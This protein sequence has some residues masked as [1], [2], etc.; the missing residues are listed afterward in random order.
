[1]DIERWVRQ[2]VVEQ[3]AV[4]LAS[5]GGSTLQSIGM[6]SCV[7][8]EGRSTLATAAAV[9][10]QARFGRKTV[11]VEFDFEKPSLAEQLGLSQS[12]GVAEVLSGQA[13]LEQSVQWCGDDLGVLVAGNMSAGV[14]G[15]L[16]QLRTTDLMGQLSQR[17]EV[18]VVDLPPLLPAGL[19]PRMSTLCE[20]IV[21]V[22][23]AGA[24]PMK[25]VQRAVSTMDS[26]PPVILNRITS[27]GPAWLD[28]ILGG[29]K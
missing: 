7:R 18:V 22:V 21:L 5:L 10:Q 6:T 4:A 15:V 17:C 1:V 20:T 9:V 24:T 11:L 26:P 12:P 23:R 19:D 28:G 2:E 3:C 16:S 13:S 29:N 8:G 27:V 25:N 14:A